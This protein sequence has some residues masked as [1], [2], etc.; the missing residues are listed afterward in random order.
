MSIS[1]EVA[2]APLATPH[3]HPPAGLLQMVTTFVSVHLSAATQVQTQRVHAEVA[4]SKVSRRELPEIRMREVA[5]HDSIDDCWLV[6]YDRVYDVT[7]FL[8]TV[9]GILVEMSIT[10]LLHSE[11][12]GV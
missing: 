2:A 10:M 12:N 5:D 11:P 9:S 3:S 4:Q 6:V 8:S 7:Q 1:S